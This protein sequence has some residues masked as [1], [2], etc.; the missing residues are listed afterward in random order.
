M[1]INQR[2]GKRGK[3]K[4]KAGGSTGPEELDD[5]NYMVSTTCQ[6]RGQLGCRTSTKGDSKN[7]RRGKLLEGSLESCWR[8]RSSH[9]NTSKRAYTQGGKKLG[10]KKEERQKGAQSPKQ[11][12]RVAKVSHY[13]VQAL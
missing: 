11:R 1:E 9:D 7:V 12:E 10:T 4:F 2:S 6:K 5:T 3:A 8:S 13:L